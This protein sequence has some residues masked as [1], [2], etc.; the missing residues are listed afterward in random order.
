MIHGTIIYSV[1]STYAEYVPYI[2]SVFIP[3]F[4]VNRKIEKTVFCIWT[5]HI[6]NPRYNAYNILERILCF[7]EVVDIS[8]NCNLLYVIVIILILNIEWLAAICHSRHHLFL[9]LTD[10]IGIFTTVFIMLPN[11]Q[12][13]FINYWHSTYFIVHFNFI[14]LFEKHFLLSVFL[15]R[16]V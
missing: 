5:V 10:K 8:D 9:S 15:V 7:N 2:Q 12:L 4:E 6:V 16:S 14:V 11:L 13:L 3:I 1:F